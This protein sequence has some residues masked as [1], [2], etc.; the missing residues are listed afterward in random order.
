MRILN[1][2][3]RIQKKELE[4]KN[5]KSL[6]T[7]VA[8]VAHEINTPLGICITAMTSFEDKTKTILWRYEN[9]KATKHDFEDYLSIAKESS[10]LVL[11]NLQTTIELVKEFK[12]VSVEQTGDQE[13]HKFYILDLLR[14]IC[15][16]ISPELTKKNVIVSLSGDENIELRAN[17][18]RFEQ[19]ITNL[20]M[21]SLIHG[22]KDTL[23][24]GNIKIYVDSDDKNFSLHYAD[25]GKGIEAEVIPRIFDPFFTTT[26]GNGGT[27]LGMYITY[28]IVTQSLGGSIRCYESPTKGARFSISAPLEFKLDIRNAQHE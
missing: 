6:A 20:I 15:K 3:K 21:N 16:K 27:G 1:K 12:N 17:K 2:N 19:V 23:D 10:E 11:A 18:Y 24:G 4:Y 26:R 7:L 25:D 22:Y 13:I 5:V 8:G 28:N 14:L 9:A